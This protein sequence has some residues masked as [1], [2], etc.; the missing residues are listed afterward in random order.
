[1][2]VIGA[3]QLDPVN[4][5]GSFV[6]GME[7][8]R[9]N[10]LARQQEMAQMEAAKQEMALRNY[11][12]S[13]DLSSPE[14]QNQLIQFGAPGAEIAKNLATIG[15]QRAQ[16][17]KADYEAQS[18]RLKDMYNLVSSATD[19]P[20]YA[21]VR[22][23]AANMGIDVSQ[24]PEQY[25]PAFVE[26]AKNS[27]LTASQRLDAE[28]RGRTADI[29]ERQVRVAERKQTLEERTAGAGEAGMVK[30]PSL[31]KGER[32]NPEA[33]RVE[34]VEGS[35]IYIKQSGKHNKDYTAINAINNQRD[36]AVGKLD[37][38]L[39]EKNQDAFSNLFG[40]YRSYA[41]RELSG[42]T[43]DL[44]SDLESLKNNL[45]AA[46]KKIIAGAGPGAIGQITEREWP[47]LEGMIAELRPTMS[48]QGAREKLEEIKVFLD[49]LSVQAADEYQTN[50]GQTQYY[51]P[52]KSAPSTPPAPNGG[53]AGRFK[54]TPI[55]Q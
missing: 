9:G 13:A 41:T 12:A 51:K 22:G 1:M 28:L 8:G 23:M 45:K 38:L 14:V 29:Q 40:G 26:Q 19:A 6:Q 2:A 35:D 53:A 31:Q 7:I 25:D 39:A 43:A 27:V 21:R 47:I 49:N 50:W 32:W 55:P 18:Q 48:E 44:R 30:P 10:R 3:T 24:I 36:L 4:T 11:L 17:S 52:P 42:K 15:T 5:L 34:A 37:R 20:S 16:A 46:G 33:Q 54:I